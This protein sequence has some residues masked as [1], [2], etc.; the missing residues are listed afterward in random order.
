MFWW[1][2]SG[3]NRRPLPCHGRN[4][5]GLQTAWRKTK[6]VATGGLDASGRQADSGLQETA[7]CMLSRAVAS[8][9]VSCLLEQTRNDF[10][11]SLYKDDAHGE[12]VSAPGVSQ[13]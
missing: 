4:I 6:D 13:A 7:R 9:R 3:S 8:R 10:C 11:I 2:W 1:T 5:N 12:P